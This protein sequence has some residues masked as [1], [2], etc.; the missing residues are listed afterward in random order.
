MRCAWYGGSR[1]PTRVR[2]PAGAGVRACVTNG[3]I[4]VRGYGV[5]G[6]GSC[7]STHTL[8][9]ARVEGWAV[10]GVGCGGRECT[11]GG[12]AVGAISANL[13][14]PV[15]PPVQVLAQIFKQSVS[16]SQQSVSQ[17]L[18]TSQSFSFSHPTVGA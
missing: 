8:T 12:V 5:W 6:G 3:V 1:L 18:F 15:R 14:P 7:L 16:I 2:S 4:G 17:L 9:P 10:V 13:R 11:G